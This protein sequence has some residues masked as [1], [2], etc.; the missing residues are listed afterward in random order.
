ML[1]A[2]HASAGVVDLSS[3]GLPNVLGRIWPN[4]TWLMGFSLCRKD[5]VSISGGCYCTVS[6]VLI[7]KMET[8]CS[9]FVGFVDFF[10]V[11]LKQMILTFLAPDSGFNFT[12][13]PVLGCF[14]HF[15]S[16]CKFSFD[17]PG[18]KLKKASINHQVIPTSFCL[19]C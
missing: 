11:N 12:W 7:L 16:D 17:L 1:R 6:S 4:T 18:G 8:L 2:T 5:Q 13:M 3:F 15:V 14:S 19:L 10:K 9:L